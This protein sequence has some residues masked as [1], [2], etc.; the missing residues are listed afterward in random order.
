MLSVKDCEEKI[1][2]IG[3][4]I[5]NVQKLNCGMD[6]QSYIEHLKRMREYYEI[7]LEEAIKRSKMNKIIHYSRID[8]MYPRNNR[9]I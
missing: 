2:K 5:E 8:L 6:Q 1:K 9:L 3:K 7:E 4:T